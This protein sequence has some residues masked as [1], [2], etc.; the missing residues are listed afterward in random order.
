M[1]GWVKHISSNFNVSSVSNQN[2]KYPIE[3]YSIYFFFQMLLMTPIIQKDQITPHPLA[4]LGQWTWVVEIR[5][6]TDMYVT[7]NLTMIFE[8]WPIDHLGQQGRGCWWNQ[9]WLLAWWQVGIRKG[10]QGFYTDQDTTSHTG[11]L[12][13][14]GWG[15]FNFSKQW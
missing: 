14:A 12:I 1:W 15:L 13:S 2:A 8:M 3:N 5:L 6:N 9:L 4:M 7:R 11:N 10:H